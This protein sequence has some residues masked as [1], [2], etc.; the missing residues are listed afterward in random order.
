MLL[1]SRLKKLSAAEKI[2]IDVKEVKR[3]EKDAQLVAENIAK[4]LE[5]R[6]SFRRAMKS[7]MNRAMKNGAKGIKDKLFRSSWWC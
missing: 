3:A 4:Q 6:V 7:C 5:E 2:S 1:R